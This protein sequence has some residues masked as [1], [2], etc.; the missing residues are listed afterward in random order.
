VT[1]R[2]VLER[3]L[4]LVDSSFR[5]ST[6]YP[7]RDGEEL[8]NAECPKASFL[9]QV[10]NRIAQRDGEESLELVLAEV[11]ETHDKVVATPTDW[12]H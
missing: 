4:Q 1:I 5:E 9:A 12:N 8:G 6:I 11:A 7:Y 3:S 2:I 10:A